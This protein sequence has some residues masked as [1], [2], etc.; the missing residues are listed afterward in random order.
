MVAINNVRLEKLADGSRLVGEV[1][2]QELWFRSYGGTRLA[3]RGEP[4]FGVALLLA[5]SRHEPII[6]DPAAPV[7]A[8]FLRAMDKV[9]RAYKQWNPGFAIA[10]IDAAIEPMPALNDGVLCSFSGGVDSLHSYLHNEDEITHLLTIGGYD[11]VSGP[12]TDFLETL[13]K[14]TR[15]ADQ[16][17]K[18]LVAIDTNTREVCDALRLKWAYAQGPILCSLAVGLGFGKY[19]I[20]ASHSYRDLKPWGTHPLTDPLWSTARTP[21][22]HDGLDAYRT[23]KVAEI[24]A[25]PDLMAHLQVC[26][27]SQ[28]T[29]CGNCSKCVRTALVLKLLGH[30]DFPIPCPD[31]LSR[32]DS[33][34]AKN[35]FGASHLWDTMQLARD[36][37]AVDIERALRAKLRKYV[38][39]RNAAGIAKALFSDKLLDRF[40]KRTW[41]ERSVLLLDPSDFR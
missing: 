3:V 22:V 1:A 15:F 18:T 30:D 23:Q 28:V 33:F 24:A 37:G 19:I 29:N 41:D 34:N 4:F 13:A 38:V 11:F 12:K 20:P 5:M 14:I 16:F 10:K 25:R 27:H 6:L 39:R 8:D 35:E 36:R 9:Q 21:V 40:R 7:S 2:G 32:V 26:W 17:G 31:P